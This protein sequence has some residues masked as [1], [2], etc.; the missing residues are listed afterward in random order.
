MKKH[1]DQKLV[2]KLLSGD[3]KSYSVFFNDYFPRLFLFAR[4][5]LWNNDDLAEDAVQ[6]AMSKAVQKLDTY[7]GEAALFTWLCTFCRH[8][9]SNI[10]A[11]EQKHTQH[12]MPLDDDKFVEESLAS[13][14]LELAKDPLDSVEKERLVGLV[15]LAKTHLP[16]L[17]S[18]LLEWKYLYGYSTKEIAE[19]IDRT[20]KATES[21]LGRARAGFKEAFAIISDAN[22]EASANVRGPIS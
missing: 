8:E 17:Y 18:D 20:P 21:L 16:K 4:A 11:R 7:R 19:R 12:T 13:M 1:R 10:I 22:N 9:I 3:E 15:H 5:R 2:K 14:A 6:H